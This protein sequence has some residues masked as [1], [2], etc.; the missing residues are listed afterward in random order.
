MAVYKFSAQVTV[1][2]H[3]TIEADSL[4]QA[5]EMAESNESVMLSPMVNG[6]DDDCWVIDDA[7][8]APQE[9]RE[10]SE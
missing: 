2:C 1:S 5:R 8:G 3:I 4:E 6:Q 7:D 10:D 9:I